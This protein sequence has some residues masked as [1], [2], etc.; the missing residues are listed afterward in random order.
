MSYIVQ[1]VSA[2]SVADRTPNVP[3]VF[4]VSKEGANEPLLTVTIDT[5]PKGI[6]V[7]RFAKNEDPQP[8][9]EMGIRAKTPEV[10]ALLR[11]KL[12]DYVKAHN[13]FHS[14]TSPMTFT[15]NKDGSFTL[16]NNSIATLAS[17]LCR[18]PADAGQPLLGEDFGPLTHALEQDIVERQTVS[19][20]SGNRKGYFITR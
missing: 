6:G 16:T 13:G 17:A 15:D 20:K 3:T 4:G 8:G 5:H 14:S 10:A 2:I 19:G 18:L 12:P 11:S 7:A 1:P 9:F